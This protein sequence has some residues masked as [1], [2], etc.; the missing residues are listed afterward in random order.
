MTATIKAPAAAAAASEALAERLLL[1]TNAVWDVFSVHLGHR[2]GYYRSLAA[3][4]AATA[5]ELA[6]RTDT[7]PRYAREWLELQAVAGILAAHEDPIGGDEARRFSLP[8][9]H[10]AVLADADDPNFLAPLAQITVGAVAPVHELVA[11]F[12]TGGGVPYADYGTDLRD[13]QAGMNRNFFLSQLGTEYLPAIPD[14]HA[15]LRANP[16][17]KIADIGCGVGWSSIALA[18][19]YPNATVD[20][21]DLDAASVE[22][23]RD[24]VADAGLDC[25][26]TIHLRDAADP[27]LA[28]RYDLA[29]AFEC[30]HDMSDPVGALRTMRRLAGDRGTVL[31][32]D[33]RAGESFDP[34]AGEIERLLYGFSVFHCL[35]VG[36]AER[37]SAG[38]GTVMRPGTFRRYAEAAGFRSVEILPLDN[39]FFRFY[40]LAV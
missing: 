37:P 38:T 31:V 19:T 25:R 16:D 34:D 40:R 11:A 39:L 2:L 26:V 20:G 5:A 14:L 35:P 13:G 4:G 27:A 7:H 10:A 36:M 6:V 3:D 8:A 21:F 28:G 17:A 30:V 1:A 29:T 22:D 32:V 15:R 24:H 18:Q 12:R 33:E 23:A 9:G